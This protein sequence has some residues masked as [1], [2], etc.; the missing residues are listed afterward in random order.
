MAALHI[1]LYIL[2]LALFLW[3]INRLNFFTST[4]IK[5]DNLWTF[6]LLKVVAGVALTLVY[7]FYYTDQTK[8]DI[9]RYFNDSKI[10]SPLLWQ[11]PKAW[12]S[13]ITGIGLNEP[14]NFQYI[15]DTQYFSHP[16]QDTVTNN[17]LII[18]I[19]SLCNYFS[20]SNIYINTLF[21]SFF[22]FVGLTGIYHAL[23]N[24]FAEFPQALCLPLFLI[25]SVVFWGSGLL[26]E[27]PVFFFLGMLFYA[28]TPRSWFS[29]ILLI[30]VSVAALAFI[31]PP[32]F[33]ALIPASAIYILIYALSAIRKPALKWTVFAALLVAY[34]FAFMVAEPRVVSA[35][36]N[37]RYEFMD[38]GLAENPG[39]R[40]VK[41]TDAITPKMLYT[42]A[43]IDGALRPFV[44]SASNKME[45]LFAVEQS[46]LWLLLL[47]MLLR[48]FQ[49]PAKEKRPL[50]AF[51]LV[52]ALVFYWMV[53]ATVPI[54]GA[55]VHYRILATPFLIIGALG[56]INLHKFKYDIN[57]LPGLKK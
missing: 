18:R 46:L 40:F 43:L 31:R 25:P 52:F 14:A 16:S 15:A 1:A 24:Y 33:I 35:I 41:W 34:A 37:K 50:I 26:K 47:V 57:R 49:L 51:A 4:G 36:I 30:L 12:L 17:Q 7:T 19:I 38:L 3:L 56:F 22:S 20:F 13:V 21:F 29:R 54:M 42:D 32:L 11:H 6:F 23:K 28:F 55:I 9:Y 45:L 48:C 5:R 8:A 27:A 53:G 39:S 2:Y 10:I 44:W